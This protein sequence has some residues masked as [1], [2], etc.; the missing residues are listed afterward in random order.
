MLGSFGIAA[1]FAA[2]M[3]LM[4]SGWFYYQTERGVIKKQND[5][6]AAQANTIKG[7][8]RSFSIYRMEVHN[9]LQQIKA[10]KHGRSSKVVDAFTQ[11]LVQM[12]RQGRKRV[13]RQEEAKGG[14]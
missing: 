5:I 1:L 4:A 9:V 10:L 3:A 7:L 2:T 6:V 11:K 13:I 14:K 12:S 8:E